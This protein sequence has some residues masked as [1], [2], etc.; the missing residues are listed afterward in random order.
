MSTSEVC[1][2]VIEWLPGEKV[3]CTVAPAT[4]KSEPTNTS[5]TSVGAHEGG[6]PLCA[7][8]QTSWNSELTVIGPPDTDAAPRSSTPT[9]T[10][11][12]RTD[13]SSMVTPGRGQQLPFRTLLYFYQR[14]LR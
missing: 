11:S 1:P 12:S 2:P 6:T 13:F 5:N 9:V 8:A 7:T 14:N 3:D 4:T 10:P